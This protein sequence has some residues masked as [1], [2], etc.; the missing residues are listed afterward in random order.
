VLPARRHGGHRQVLDGAFDDG[1]RHVAPVADHVH[2]AGLR[3]SALDGPHLRHVAGGLVPP[4]R[5][6]LLLGV[7]LEEGAD[8]GVGLESPQLV[9]AR[10]ELLYPKAEIP[11]LPL[12]GDDLQRDVASEALLARDLDQV[13]DEVGLG[14]DRELGVGIEHQPQERRPGAVHPDHERGRLA[15]AA[16]ESAQEPHR[17]PSTYSRVAPTGSPTG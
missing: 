16:P 11:P 3:Q 1:E 2:E 5:L 17:R 10:R 12:G 4:S 8:R 14:G 13:G 15:A 7:E 6:A 9:E